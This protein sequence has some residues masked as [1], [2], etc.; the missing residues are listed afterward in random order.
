MDTDHLL[1]TEWQYNMLPNLLIS[2]DFTTARAGGEQQIKSSMII[3]SFGF[4]GSIF[5]FLQ[6]I[7]KKVYWHF[8]EIGRLT[9]VSVLCKWRYLWI[10]D[11]T[12][13][14]MFTN[15]ILKNVIEIVAFAQVYT[16]LVIENRLW[17]Q[18]IINFRE[19]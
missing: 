5:T 6:H 12:H 16:I 18:K 1:S 10:F 4:T 19:N 9:Q 17:T 13:Y 15:K 2:L 14:G 11:C 7:I 3:E 8:S